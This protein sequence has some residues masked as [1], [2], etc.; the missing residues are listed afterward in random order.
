[1]HIKDL[2]E[3]IVFSAAWKDKLATQ[4][5]PGQMPDFTLGRG[6][7][8]RPLPT[9]PARSK[10]CLPTDRRMKFPADEALKQPLPRAIALHFF[11]NHELLAIEL[12][13]WMIYRMPLI[14]EQD[15]QLMKTLWITMREEQ[16]HFE[17]YLERL[18]QM[19]YSFGDFPVNGYFWSF[20]A[21][22]TNWDQYFSLMSLTFEA[23]NLDFAF[24][25]GQCFAQV[26]DFASA[27]V[28]D[29]IY[30]DEIKHVRTGVHW[31]GQLL[32]PTQSLWQYYCESLPSPVT[33]ARS[34]GK[35]FSLE[36]RRL[37][38]LPEEFI[39]ELAQFDDGFA[40]TKRKFLK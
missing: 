11:A 18:Q 21:K 2:A 36:H 26:G 22:L 31:M 12:M 24:Y 6:P 25:Y 10:S 34:K 28:M 3:Q 1:M 7:G 8:V 33:A 16:Q 15:R 17:L 29:R 4:I 38:Q 32:P 19:G 40:V 13:A 5:I 14:T 35:G 39:K 37:A 20:A 30:Q 23:A 9:F 27:V